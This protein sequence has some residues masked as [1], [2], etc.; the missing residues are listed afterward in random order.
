M[1][2]AQLALVAVIPV[3]EEKRTRLACDDFPNLARNGLARLPAGTSG[4]E[5]E[6]PPL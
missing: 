4:Q 3:F 6:A 2:L 1:R 5:G